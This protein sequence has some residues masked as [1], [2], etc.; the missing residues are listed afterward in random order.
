MFMFCVL[1]LKTRKKIRLSVCLY[2]RGFLAVDTIIFAGV[3]GS[4]KNLVGVFY[5]KK[6]SSSVEIQSKIMIL[7]LIRI[8]ILIK[9]LRNDT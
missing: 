6:F 9:T 1:E 5:V 8:L 2:V 3:S 4:K 7:I